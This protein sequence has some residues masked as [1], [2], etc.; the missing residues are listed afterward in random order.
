MSVPAIIF[1]W[2]LPDLEIPMLVCIT[3]AIAI[4]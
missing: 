1:T 4:Y 3:A 2:F